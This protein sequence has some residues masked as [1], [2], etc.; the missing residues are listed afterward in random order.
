MVV[1]NP[2]R[3]Y[4]T[5][6]TK[7]NY[8]AQRTIGYGLPLALLTLFIG[9]PFVQ[10]FIYSLTNWNGFS[11]LNFI[12]IKNYLTLLFEDERFQESLAH[13]ALLTVVFVVQSVGVALLASYLIHHLRSARGKRVA[14]VLIMVPS[15]APTVAMLLLWS[16]FLQPAGLVNQILSAVGLDFLTANWLGDPNTVLIALMLVGFPWL[17]GLNTLIFMSGFLSV[18]PSLYEAAGI[19]G[20]TR[21]KVF[22]YIELPAIMPQIGLL[23]LIAVITAIQNYESIFLLTG[24]GPGS[25]S[26][27]P[28]M[29][30]YNSAFR[31]SSFGYAS[32]IGVIMFL[33]I[34]AIAFGATLAGRLVRSEKHA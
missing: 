18:D 13:A 2:P 14:M 12:G 11:E 17:N 34:A 5:R 8:L 10:A 25:S 9:V 26:T 6:G 1:V 32:A 7:P 4:R 23:S 15:V 31:Y 24:G 19:E 16:N 21:P 27:V 3:P 22:W 33:V 29:E 28:G 30:L 20:A